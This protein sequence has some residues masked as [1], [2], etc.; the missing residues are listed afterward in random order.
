VDDPAVQMNTGPGGPSQFPLRTQNFISADGLNIDLSGRAEELHQRFDGQSALFTPTGGVGQFYASAIKTPD[1]EARF[2][3]IRQ[4]EIFADI[5]DTAQKVRLDS[6]QVTAADEEARI[7]RSIK[8]INNPT[9]DEKRLLQGLE[10]FKKTLGKDGHQTVS[11]G[12]ETL[13]LWENTV[14]NKFSESLKKT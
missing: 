11:A 10:D 2:L 4:G 1:T 13:S 7:R 3:Y 12:G 5:Q 8:D 9:D 14:A 6:H